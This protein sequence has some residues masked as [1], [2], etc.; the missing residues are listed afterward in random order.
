MSVHTFHFET[1]CADS[2][3]PRAPGQ[4]SINATIPNTIILLST[5][6]FLVPQVALEA[7]ELRILLEK[8]FFWNEVVP[9]TKRLQHK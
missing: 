9:Y 8:K 7:G 1:Y 4:V 3:K 2:R 6:V 5:S